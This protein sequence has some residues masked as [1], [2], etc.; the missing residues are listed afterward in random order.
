MRARGWGEHQWFPKQS[1]RNPALDGTVNHLHF[2]E[3]L[4]YLNQKNSLVSWIICSIPVQMTPR[5]LALQYTSL[6]HDIS[7]CQANCSD[8][9]WA[10]CTHFSTSYPIASDSYSPCCQLLLVY[11]LQETDFISVICRKPSQSQLESHTLS[12]LP[13]TTFFRALSCS[14]GPIR[15]SNQVESEYRVAIR[16]SGMIDDAYTYASGLKSSVWVD[17]RSWV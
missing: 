15:N 10:S 8:D 1:K 12:H 7:S 14:A 16:V 11:F 4:L 2:S 5:V 3:L 17:S 9:N 13:S 6:K